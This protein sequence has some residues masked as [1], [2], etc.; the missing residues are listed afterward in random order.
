M[1]ERLVASLKI[2]DVKI[3]YMESKTRH[4]IVKT[5]EVSRKSNI[6]IEKAKDTLRLMT[7]QYIRPAINKLHHK[8]R[9]DRRAVPKSDK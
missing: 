3:K 6:G 5:E 1:T 9:V 4:S 7:H 2:L 8:Y